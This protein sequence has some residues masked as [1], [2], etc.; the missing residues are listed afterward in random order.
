MSQAKIT[1]ESMAAPRLKIR[2]L[3][4]AWVCSFAVVVATAVWLLVDPRAAPA[5]ALS[6]GQGDKIAPDGVLAVTAGRMAT[7]GVLWLMACI[8]FGPI[9]V[10]LFFGAPKQRSLRSW[11]ALTALVACWLALFASWHEFAWA[12]QRW[13]LGR[14]LA[15][16]QTL[17]DKLS[18]QWPSD[19][20]KLAGL[21]DFS[22]YPIGSPRTL[23]VNA[24]DPQ[25][26]G[27]RISLVDRSAD[28]ALRFRIAGDETGAWLEWHPEGEAPGDF[29]DGVDEAHSLLR[30][31][32]LRDGWHL[33]RYY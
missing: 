32:P 12:G 31:S 21:G 20:G 18:H 7:L 27:P 24:A 14:Q 1:D 8:C 4:L 5:F 6:M 9:V 13:R 33:S 16:L 11:L 28:G 30:F 26:A 22:A 3:A 2:S 10:G 25:A 15:P 17:A 29:T 23:L 19:D